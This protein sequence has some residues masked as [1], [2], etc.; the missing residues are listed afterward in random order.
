M[1]KDC[2][3]R[4]YNLQS[5]QVSPDT[6]VQLILSI[7]LA[8]TSTWLQGQKTQFTRKQS[9]VCGPCQFTRKQSYVC[10]PCENQR[11]R[12]R[13]RAFWIGL[14]GSSWIVSMNECQKLVLEI[15][16]AVLNKQPFHMQALMAMML[17][18]QP[19]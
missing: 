16:A 7:A 2:K 6:L 13:H 18:E 9:Y 1:F 3:A 8:M 10:G 19:L 4:V 17:R 5:S 15:M 11:T 12:R 14:Y